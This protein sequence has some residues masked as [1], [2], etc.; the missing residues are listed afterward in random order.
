MT[1]TFDLKRFAEAQRGAYDRALSELRQGAK[2]S[3]WMWYIFPQFRGLGQSAMAYRYGIASLDEARAYLSHPVL[4]PRLIAC[5]KLALDADKASASAIFPSPDDLK[6]RSCMTL[7]ASGTGAGYLLRRA[8]KILWRLAGPRDAAAPRRI[9]I[10][11]LALEL[12]AF[13]EIKSQI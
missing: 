12:S 9:G 2:Q 10:G 6:F 8:A 13:G 11:R 3:H 1:D 7:F 4:G 5:T